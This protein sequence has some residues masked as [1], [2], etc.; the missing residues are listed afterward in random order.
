VGLYLPLLVRDNLIGVLEAYGPEAL[1]DE[2]AETLYS[3]ASQAAS[4]LE[5]ARLYTELSERENQLRDLGRLIRAQEEER[6]RVAYDIHDGLAQSA[7]AAHQHLQAFARHRTVCSAQD[8]EEL[9]EALDLVREL[10]GEARQVIHNLRPTVLDDFGLAAAVRLQGA[11]LRADGLEI[12][13]EESLGDRRLPPEIETTLFRVVQEALTNIR[14]HAQA[15]RGRVVL[16][17]PGNAVRLLVS[18][19]GRGFVPNGKPSPNGHGERVGL[20]G[21]RERVSLLGGKF[22]C[23]SEPGR[24]TTIVAEIE[25]PEVGGERDREG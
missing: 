24:G 21:M 6:R 25:L 9:N 2:G 16:D 8:Q 15:T 13:L 10:V 20:S 22:E 5:N 1:L 19:E 18:D 17:G 14:K 12:D 11:T 4:A 7:A 23:H 3:L